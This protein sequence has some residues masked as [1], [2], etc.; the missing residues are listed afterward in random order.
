MGRDK[1]HLYFPLFCHKDP[2]QS[3]AWISNF[4]KHNNFANKSVPLHLKGRP[5]V[6][7]LLRVSI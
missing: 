1:Q 2:K 4:Q 6:N 3:K 7:S 5:K